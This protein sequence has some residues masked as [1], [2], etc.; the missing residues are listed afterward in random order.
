MLWNGSHLDVFRP[1][2]IRVFALSLVG[3]SSMGDHGGD[4][5]LTIANSHSPC[6][7]NLLPE[8]LR[9]KLPLGITLLRWNHHTNL[10]LGQLPDL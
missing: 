3:S 6:H 10:K 9:W 8:P 4:E 7:S 5:V 2:L 1:P